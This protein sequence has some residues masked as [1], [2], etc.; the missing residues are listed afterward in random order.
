MF[1]RCSRAKITKI[2]V[3]IT[4][5][6]ITALWLG[7]EHVPDHWPSFLVYI[8][9]SRPASKPADKH[10]QSN[11]DLRVDMSGPHKLHSTF[12]LPH[13]RSMYS[14]TFTFDQP[15]LK[16]HN[17][18][19]DRNQKWPQDLTDKDE[20]PSKQ[21]DDLQSICDPRVTLIY[22]QQECGD[23]LCSEYLTEKDWTNFHQ[24][25]QKFYS[26]FNCTQQ[27]GQVCGHGACR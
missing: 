8:R 11:Q 23:V 21:D 25:R 4:L 19:Q 1:R 15:A 24:C 27:V 12:T 20:I 9:Y 6:I 16:L 14:R 26:K 17:S 7:G 3:M 5:F 13:T 10:L 18:H 2:V 22:T